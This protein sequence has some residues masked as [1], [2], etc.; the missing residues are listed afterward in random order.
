[1]LVFGEADSLPA[2]EDNPAASAVRNLLQEHRLRYKV[3]VKNPE[4]GEYITKE[5]DKPGPTVM[6]STS[7]R[8]LGYQLDT[9]VFSLDV[10]D[11]PDKIG[12]A[13]IAQAKLELHG[14]TAPDGALIAY[15]S[16]LQA[17]APWEVS[18]AIRYG[19]GG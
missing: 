4:N 7:T 8:R 10:I 9:R 17:L 19:A 16:Y 11:T 3:P 18:G 2:G 13:L 5:I 1:M 6:I 15:Q 12:A 14:A